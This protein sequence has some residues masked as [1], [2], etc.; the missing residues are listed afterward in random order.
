MIDSYQFGNMVIHG[1]SYT[2]DVIVTPDKIESN[3]RRK[4]GHRL[5][6]EDI[7]Q[8]IERVQPK[9]LVVGSGKFGVLKVD[10]DVKDFLEKKNI[11][12]YGEPTEKAVKIFNRLILVEEK[13]VGAFHLTC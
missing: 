7:Q 12:L 1:V 11:T 10:Q 6:L 3:W 13:I 5:H 9:A 8:T 2:A 4:E